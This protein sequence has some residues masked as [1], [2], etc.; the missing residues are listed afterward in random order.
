MKVMQIDVCKCK[1]KIQFDRLSTGSVYYKKQKVLRHEETDLFVHAKYKTWNLTK[2]R[3][4]NV[5]C[6]LL[7]ILFADKIEDFP[8][9]IT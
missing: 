9:G 8:L 3:V 4:I 6:L 5:L 1:F 7:S 2:F